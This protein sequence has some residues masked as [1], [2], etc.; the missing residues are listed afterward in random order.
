M[1]FG[2]LAVNSSKILIN[3]AEAMKNFHNLDLEGFWE[4]DC[5]SGGKLEGKITA[6]T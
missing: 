3:F 6:L 5:S 4:L 2:S 1:K